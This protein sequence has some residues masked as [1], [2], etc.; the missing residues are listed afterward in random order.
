M[1]SSLWFNMAAGAVL[2]TGLGIMGI[3][4]FSDNLYAGNTE[5]VGYPVDA[6]EGASGSAAKGPELLPNWGALFADPAQLA[7]YQANGEKVTKVCQS[8]HD[9]SPAGAN[10][11]GPALA[12]VLGRA[13][14]SHAGFAYSEPMKAFGQSWS[15]DTL[16]SFLQSPKK[17]VDGTS[18]SFAGLPKAED[19]IA[20]IAYLRSISPSAPP[21]PAP[22]PAR[23][24]A[25]AAAAAVTAAPANEVAAGNATTNAV[26]PTDAVAA[27]A[28]ATP[29]PPAAPK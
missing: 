4:T 22:D 14:G 19:R 12:G 20:A 21:I 2:A 24:P 3:Q 27:A 17:L 13:A 25:A 9:F 16:N 10:K 6:D 29:A 5:A 28:P 1:K 11:T 15:Y 8:C 23:D 26:A 18:M 7:A